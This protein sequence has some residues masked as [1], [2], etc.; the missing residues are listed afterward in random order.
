[1]QINRGKKDVDILTRLYPME[2]TQTS[3]KALC[4]LNL[5]EQVQ[6]QL[7]IKIISDLDTIYSSRPDDAKFWKEMQKEIDAHTKNGF[8]KF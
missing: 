8:W 4:E 6:L 3:V 1:M 2:R 5:Q 7:T